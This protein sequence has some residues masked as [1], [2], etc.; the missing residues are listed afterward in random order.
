[1]LELCQVFTR[2]CQSDCYTD[3]IQTHIHIST[4]MPGLALDP[5]RLLYGEHVIG[6]PNV[7]LHLCFTVCERKIS[8]GS[9]VS[10]MP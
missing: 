8:R 5:A 6:I 7:D 9:S 1:M 10:Q 2:K 4:T 3:S